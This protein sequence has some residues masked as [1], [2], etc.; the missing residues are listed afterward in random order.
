MKK[1][2]ITGGGGF[3]AKHLKTALST[4][5]KV[6]APNRLELDL[7]NPENIS[8]VMEDFSP[9]IIIHTAV[10]DAAPTFTKNDPNLVLRY[11]LEMFLNLYEYRNYVNK[12]IYFGSGAEFNK[13]LNDYGLAKK[14]MNELTLLSN[15][16]YNLR[17]YGVYGEGDD[18]RYRYIS[19][20][21]VKIALNQDITLPYEMFGSFIYI[22][23]LIRIINYV[24]KN[25]LFY[26]SY[27][28][29]TD[30]LYLTDIAK[31][32]LK[33]SNKK[34]NIIIKKPINKQYIAEDEQTLLI[35]DYDLNNNLEK[36]YNYYLNNKNLIDPN[37]FEY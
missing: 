3:I 13:P 33:I 17:L 12:I 21:C 20:M 14:I 19:N 24:I 29:Y 2:L 5:Y 8:K 10:Y 27:D 26:H 35:I 4:E 36:M 37:Q 7:L 9:D 31:S 11:N 30:Q 28:V 34:L 25:N 6:Y 16:I 32:L 1:I 15:N 18:W 23:D 22:D